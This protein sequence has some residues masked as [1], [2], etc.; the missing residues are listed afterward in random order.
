MEERFQD[1]ALALQQMKNI[2]EEYSAVKDEADFLTVQNLRE[3]AVAVLNLLGYDLEANARSAM[4][5]AEL[6][7]KR[8]HFKLM[9]EYRSDAGKGKRFDTKEDA[10]NQAFLDSA[11]LYEA[12]IHAASFYYL[13][14]E[15]KENTE[16]FLN[17]VASRIRFL[18]KDNQ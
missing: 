9:V 7:Y 13:V 6:Q 12:K 4:D 15:M 1:R 10:S 8:Q 14:K 11:D 17:A 5:L 3:R 2:V 16:A 18:L